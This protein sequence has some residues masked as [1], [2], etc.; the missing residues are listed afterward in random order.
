[1]IGDAIGVDT[2]LAI[3]GLITLGTALVAAFLPVIRDV[4]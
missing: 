4:P 2:F 1:V 3:A